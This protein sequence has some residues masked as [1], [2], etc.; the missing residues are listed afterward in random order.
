MEFKSKELPN[1]PTYVKYK[2]Q[3]HTC[4]LFDKPQ[5]SNTFLKKYHSIM[6]S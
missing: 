1:F 6:L 2:K 4:L 5:I 3:A